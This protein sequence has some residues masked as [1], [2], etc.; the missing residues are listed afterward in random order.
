L[1]LAKSRRNSL[2]IAFIG[3]GNMAISLIRGLLSNGMST[4]DLIAADP[5][6][7]QRA[8]AKGIGIRTEADNNSAI[9]EADIIV[10]AV[11]PQIA[12]QVLKSLNTIKGTQLVISVA[13]GIG[14]DSLQSW[15]PEGQPIVRCMP[16]TPALVGAGM[17][18]LY[19]NDQV[20]PKHREA[21][22]R[23]LEAAGE[24]V[25]VPSEGLLDAVTAVS[26]SGPAYFFL[27][28]EY[29]A[30]TGTALGLD[31]D[32]S[33]MLTLQTAL[34]AALMAQ[35]S[36]E[37]LANLRQNVTSPGGTTE[38]AINTMLEHGMPEAIA[39]ALQAAQQRSIQLA[40]EFGNP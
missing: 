39:S 27:L 15:L 11:K 35:Q 25:W 22:E 31:A 21:A 24:V 10:V 5:S 1:V 4:A 23:V 37:P 36:T 16:N 17:T 8:K 13:A 6:D 28:M 12:G 40:K 19:A 33:R 20:N 30:K 9:S 7:D 34:G 32:T 2:T 26:G 38:A 29:M 3:A 18:G 14:L